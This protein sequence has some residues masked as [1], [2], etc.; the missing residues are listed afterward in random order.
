M[1]AYALFDA[2]TDVQDSFLAETERRLYGKKRRAIGV[3]LLAAV[4]I[5]LLC[6]TTA[7]AVDVDF[8]QRVLSLFKVAE[9]LPQ[10]EVSQSVT[11]QGGIQADYVF[12][13]AYARTEG[14]MFIVCTDETERKQGS[15]YAAY[16]YE[17]GELVRQENHRFDQ[18]YTFRGKTYRLV[19][20]W[21]EHN[22]RAAITWVPTA[23]EQRRLG[24]EENWRLEGNLTTQ[25]RAKLS[26][27][28]VTI[29][30]RTGALTDTLAGCDTSRFPEGTFV[31]TWPD[32]HGRCLLARLRDENTYRYDRYYFDGETV[33]PISTLC[34][35]EPSLAYLSGNMLVYW[36][37]ED[38]APPPGAFSAWRIDLDTMERL[39]VFT[40]VPATAG[41]ASEDAL[42]AAGILPVY[43]EFPNGYPLTPGMVSGGSGRLA[44]KMAEDRTVTLIDTQTSRSIPVEGYTLPDVPEGDI[45]FYSNPART[46]LLVALED[47]DANY[48]FTRIAVL[49]LKDGFL[50]DRRSA[51]AVKE[52]HI[53]WLDDDRFIISCSNDDGQY[54]MTGSWFYIYDLS[55]KSD[56]A[57]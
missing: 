28:P 16:A 4:L 46:R 50:L 22:G 23:D 56:N 42:L 10:Q 57:E 15:H 17:N 5:V 25:Y 47:R 8:R 55:E 45:W 21:A 43:P 49:G 36:Q 20:D 38:D 32:E 33:T 1:D 27:W 9:T 19:F 2:L 39:P 24:G 53:T 29:D 44:L 48:N 14:G 3:Y 26:S 11:L 54:G 12:V 51:P 40:D 52:R 41:Y 18:T 37:W 6:F 7:M 34:G 30:L 35:G 31:E 13:P